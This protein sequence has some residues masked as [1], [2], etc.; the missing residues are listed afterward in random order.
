MKPNHLI[1]TVIFLMISPAISFAER[2]EYPNGSVYEGEVRNGKAN[3]LGMTTHGPR[4]IRPGDIY[5]GGFR[6]GKYHG[7]GKY[8]FGPSSEFAGDIYTGD[9][10]DDK[11]H[12][13]GKYTYATGDLLEG[14]FKD[15]YPNG[16][17]K[18][19]WGRT[20]NAG[21]IYQG[22]FSGFKRNGFGRYTFADGRIQE[23]EW[24]DDKFVKSLKMTDYLQAQLRLWN[25]KS[26]EFKRKNANLEVALQTLKKP[27]TQPRSYDND[28]LIAAASGTGFF[29]SSAGHLIT[30]NHVI[31]HCSEVKL[32]I[33]GQLEDAQVIARD[34]VN[35]LALLKSSFKNP[36]T[37]PISPSNPKLLQDIYAAGFPFGSSVSSSV[38][39][40]KGIVSSLSGVADNFSN[41]Q[42][43][44]A[45]QPGNS[46]GPIV[47]DYGNA[48]AV[49]VAKL[50]LE[51]IIKAYGVVP[52]NTNFGIKATVVRNLLE[53]NNIQVSTPNTTKMSGS[54]LGQRITQGTVHL[55]C[56]M[57]MAQIEQVRDQKVLFT[58]YN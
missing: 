5:Q 2:I 54:E 14:E 20:P 30:N 39:V 13:F 7:F 28:E 19:I 10:R 50:D 45:L 23:G 40:T 58:D 9:F 12:G 34:K 48:V 8:M 1:I 53:A 3:G 22:G 36:T 49:A 44:A 6:D 29:V 17:G 15:G 27:R 56:L 46:D 16:F 33:S 26:Q 55:S 47:D 42:I 4:S 38:K 37:I 51:K 35:D 31:S 43:D 32:R 25:Q 18:F 21:D 52:E 41:V 24:K 57:T 11:S